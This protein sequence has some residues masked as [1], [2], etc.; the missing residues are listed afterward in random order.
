MSA[1]LRHRLSAAR[2]F[3]SSLVLT[4]TAEG[5]TMTNT[6]HRPVPLRTCASIGLAF[7]L[8]TGPGCG[9][10]AG[11]ET[12]SDAG[13]DTGSGAVG[14]GGK[15][16]SGRSDTETGGGSGGSSAAGASGGTGGAGGTMGTRPV[17]VPPSPSSTVL[18]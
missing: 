18:D 3:L 16:G 13:D 7:V 11:P 8:T 1:F 14:A 6:A 9:S 2:F 10:N 12:S 17:A 5:T 15:G 4:E